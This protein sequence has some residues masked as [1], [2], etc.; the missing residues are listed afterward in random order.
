MWDSIFSSIS[1]I[2]LHDGQTCV[3]TKNDLESA[4]YDSVFQLFPETIQQNGSKIDFAGKSYIISTDY[5]SHGGITKIYIKMKN[6]SWAK[7]HLMT[8]AYSRTDY[9]PFDEIMNNQL[10]EKKS[11]TR[12]PL[13]YLISSVEPGIIMDQDCL[14]WLSPF[15]RCIA[16][17]AMDPKNYTRFLI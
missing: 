2:T 5:S 17:I 12:P 3:Y 9:Q 15:A 4:I 7:A 16:W 14:T 6:P 8:C 13:P 10:G 1:H 11:V